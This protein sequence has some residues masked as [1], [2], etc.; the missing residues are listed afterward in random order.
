MSVWLP[1]LVGGWLCIFGIITACS[2]G[3]LGCLGENNEGIYDQR[4]LLTALDSVIARSGVSTP[5]L[6]RLCLKCG[7]RGWTGITG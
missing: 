3:Y 1:I 5:D 7:S 2:A 4:F 6:T